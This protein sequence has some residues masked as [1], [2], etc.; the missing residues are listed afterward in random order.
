MVRRS[1]IDFGLWRDIP[2]NRL[3]IPLDT[4]IMRVSGCMGLTKRKSPGWKTALEITNALKQFDPD[5]PLKY[6]FALCHRGI[7]GLC[8]KDK[9]EDCDLKEFKGPR[10]LL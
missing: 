6:D 7:Q 8:G 3:V 4:H 1:D 9:C 5:D 2:E 10:A